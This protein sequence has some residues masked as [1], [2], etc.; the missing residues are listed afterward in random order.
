M[1]DQPKVKRAPRSK[2]PAKPLPVR[3]LMEVA[4]ALSPREKAEFLR[5]MAA[6]RDRPSRPAA[7]L[8]P[9]PA[10]GFIRKAREGED[11]S[12]LLVRQLDALGTSSED[13]LNSALTS[14]LG[15][16]SDSRGKVSSRDYNAA[17]AVLAAVQPT[18]ELE[19]MLACQ[20]VA[21]NEG[22]M[23]CARMIGSASAFDVDQAQMWGGLANKF[24]RT[25]VA[26]MEALAKMRR[27]GE[28]VVKHVHVYEG[29]Q[30]VV[31][32]TIHQHRGG[33]GA[34]KDG[35]Q[36]DATNAIAGS[37]ALPRPDP[38][39]DGMPLPSNAERPMQDARRDESGAAEGEPERMEARPS[40]G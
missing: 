38:F 36:S 4:N 16:L 30:A 26:Q 6:Y 39:R 20:M 13:F 27:G 28:Q 10:G 25:S 5:A 21:A 33:G 8:E 14:V 40:V 15:V 1:T 24:M 32:D 9:N 12:I 23:R 37:A 19:A 3:D 29:G 18:N 7:A 2:K 11:E 35:G 17:L 31:A 22:A 34:S